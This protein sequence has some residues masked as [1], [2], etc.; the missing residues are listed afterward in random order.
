MARTISF[1]AF[2]TEQKQ[3]GAW[4][5][6]LA[7][8]KRW[9]EATPKYPLDEPL[10]GML[11]T[12]AMPAD[13]PEAAALQRAFDELAARGVETNIVVE[14]WIDAEALAAA[15]FIHI[16]GVEVDD[17][18]ESP[19]ISGGDLGPGEPCPRCG[20]ALG[21]TE[22]Q[23]APFVLDESMLR[24]SARKDAPE[25]KPGPGGWDVVNLPNAQRAVSRRFVELLRE[26]GLR[27]WAEQPILSA[28]TGE[29]S[30]AM[31][32]L[33]AATRV[34]V[35]CRLHDTSMAEEICP[36]CGLV[37]DGYLETGW[38]AQRALVDELALFSR[39]SNLGSS[40][41]LRRSLYDQMIARGLNGLEPFKTARI[42]DHSPPS[43]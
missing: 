2:D 37:I 36:H 20:S 31:V 28:A 26:S 13:H 34:T 11:Q 41:Y 39:S 35:T 15:D 30:T 5:V 8:R 16:Y 25:R 1:G 40:L 23:G 18:P 14:D 27:G 9:N 17:T 12:S 33:M 38:Y 4:Q 42:C 32:Q 43:R 3:A 7:L 19:F 24:S 29:P 22:R 21:W 6:A 10:P